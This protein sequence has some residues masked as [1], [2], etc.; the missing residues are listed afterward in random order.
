[1]W[2]AINQIFTSHHS[3][4]CWAHL[5]VDGAWHNVLPNASDGVANVHLILATAKANGKQVYVVLD[6][7][8]NITQVYL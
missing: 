1:M 6:D 5:A 2:T 4:N 7:A 3:Q 8:K